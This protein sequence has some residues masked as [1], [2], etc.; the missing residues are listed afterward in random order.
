MSRYSRPQNAE[1]QSSRSRNTSRNSQRLKLD[2][3]STN[4]AIHKP[5]WKNPLV[6]IGCVS[7]VSILCYPIWQ[8]G[9][10][11][12]VIAIGAVDVSDS[13]IANLEAVKDVCI[14]R[15]DKLIAGDVSITIDFSDRAE[16]TGSQTIDNNTDS[17][18]QCQTVFT[19]GKERSAQ[20]SKRGGTDPMAVID[21]IEN[22]V[23]SERSKDNQNPV[24]VTLWL[25]AAEP[26][27]GKPAY[28]F[29]DFQKR[30]EA[31]T[32]DRGKVAIIGTTGELAEDLEKR[33]AK[34]SSVF[35]CTAKDSADCIRKTFD[36]ARTP[37]I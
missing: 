17:S 14:V 27:L 5:I 15:V 32:N 33:F 36:A 11:T 26:V 21:R 24:V 16:K 1:L 6:L 13:G 23:I 19:N 20:I 25:D 35:L 9:K 8:D 34:N 7:A 4:P 28:D 3:Q 2:L 37:K 12:R 29:N 31:I 18:Q 22:A 10:I 30:V